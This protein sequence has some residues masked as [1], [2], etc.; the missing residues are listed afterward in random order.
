MFLL[1]ILILAPW[2]VDS[3]VRTYLEQVWKSLTSYEHFQLC[4][5]NSLSIVGGFHRLNTDRV[6]LPVLLHRAAQDVSLSPLNFFSL[7]AIL[8][9]LTPLTKQTCEG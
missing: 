7:R 5:I 3:M 2:L 4:G 1:Y 8:I 6:F 9:F